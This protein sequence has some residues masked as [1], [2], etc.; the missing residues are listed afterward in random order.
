MQAS[1]MAL[2]PP[3]QW[4][5]HVLAYLGGIGVDHYRDLLHNTLLKMKEL[6]FSSMRHGLQ[7]PSYQQLQDVRM[8][9]RGGSSSAVEGEALGIRHG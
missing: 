1:M 9:S 4:N 3:D 2:P 6:L 5:D 8:I 7:H